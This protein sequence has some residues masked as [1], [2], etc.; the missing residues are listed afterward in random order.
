MKLEI[1]GVLVRMG[2]KVMI[3]RVYGGGS[4]TSASMYVLCYK[5]RS[6]GLLGISMVN[7]LLRHD[8]LK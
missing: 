1:L 2:W 4:C 8:R 5:Y 6:L 3:V 7:R